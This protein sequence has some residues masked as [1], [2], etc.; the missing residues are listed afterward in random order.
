MSYLS[1]ENPKSCS[2]SFKFPKENDYLNEKIRSLRKSRSG[3]VSAMTRIINKLTEQIN[4]NSDVK[5]IQRYEFNLQN[6][7]QNI[8][9]IYGQ[10][11]RGRNRRKGTRKRF[12]FLY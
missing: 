8:H 5:E 10:V 9:D 12:K 4:L 7:I 3:Y 2:K 11:T 6:A 1:S